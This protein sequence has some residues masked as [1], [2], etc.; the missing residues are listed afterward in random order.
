M[1]ESDQRSGAHPEF[2]SRIEFRALARA[3]DEATTEVR[4]LPH[5]RMP[6]VYTAVAT[7]VQRIANGPEPSRPVAGVTATGAAADPPE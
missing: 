2:Y 1:N 3:C 5:A 7:G 4:H 6:Q